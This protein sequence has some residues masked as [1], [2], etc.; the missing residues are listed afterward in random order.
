MLRTDYGRPPDED[1]G[2]D[3][4]GELAQLVATTWLRLAAW[5]VGASLRTSGRL[6]RAAADP[7]AAGELYADLARGVRAYAREFLGIVELDDRV[8]ELT[9]LAGSTLRRPGE[10]RPALELRAHGAELLRR[11]ADVE[12]G[13]DAETHPAYPRILTELAPDEARI[14]R[15]LAIAGPQPVVDIRA[16][17]LI[18]RGSQLIARGLNMLGAQAG[19][20]RRDRVPVYVDNLV[21]L[22]LAVLSDQP[23]GGPALY[24]VLEAQPEVLGPLKATPRSRT[25]HRS[26]RLTA[27][28]RDFC[29]V[30]LPLDGADQ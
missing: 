13:D 16:A 12:Q 25:V 20:G 11:A 10:R 22:G 27:L 23:L 5:G 19:L 26:L 9:L 17:N 3:P 21:R 4:L 29:D 28:G 6:A 7:D 18:G 24:Q 14:L 30:C 8:R 1:P 15:L 2:A